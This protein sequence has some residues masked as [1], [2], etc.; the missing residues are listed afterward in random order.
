[1]VFIS[2]GAILCFF[3]IVFFLIFKYFRKYLFYFLIIGLIISLL[4]AEWGSRNY[5]SSTFYFLHTRIWELICGSLLAY[6]EVKLGRRGE[7]SSWARLFPLFGLT[8]I[9]YAVFLF[10]DKIFHP[11]FYT[12]IPIVGVTLI[13]WFGNKA[14]LI[15]KILSTKLFVG[16]GL[17]FTLFIY[18]TIQSFHLQKYRN[19][20]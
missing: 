13:L 10:D 12:L 3:P 11:S 8:L 4:L 14:D 5:P 6:Y 1:M 15:T 7:N 2:G 16:I 9:F 18:G 20:F 17:I 19:I